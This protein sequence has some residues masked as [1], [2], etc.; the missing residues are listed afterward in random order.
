MVMVI[1]FD[2]DETLVNQR[3]AEAVAGE[4]FLKVYGPLLPQSYNVSG[5]CRLWRALREKHAPPFWRGLIPCQEQRRRRI[6]ELFRARE[7]HLDDAEADTRF[8]FYREHYRGAW[9]LFDDVLP[10]LRALSPLR[11]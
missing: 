10:C 5:F 2:I 7:P 4:H 3:H 11:L 1:F 8:A 9:S 6:R